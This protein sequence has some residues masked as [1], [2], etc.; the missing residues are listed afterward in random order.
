M[1]AVGTAQQVAR[2]NA[3]GK[4]QVEQRSRDAR[5]LHGF[6]GRGQAQTAGDEGLWAGG[7]EHLQLVSCVEAVFEPDERGRAAAASST[8]S[9]TYSIVWVKPSAPATGLGAPK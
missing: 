8:T 5:G 9:P 1:V 7:G 3:E 6:A 4:G 2:A